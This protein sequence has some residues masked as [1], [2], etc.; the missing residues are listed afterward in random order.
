M[1]GYWFTPMQGT[2]WDYVSCWKISYQH[3][4][5]TIN[6]RPNFRHAKILWVVYFQVK[7]TIYDEVWQF[8]WN[9]IV[10]EDNVK[11]L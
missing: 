2:M 3:E 6:C 7:C 11:I 4:N 5:F 1:Y 9:T 10:D 8:F